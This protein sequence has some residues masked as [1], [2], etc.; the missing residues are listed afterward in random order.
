MVCDV[1]I[2]AFS[3][4]IL[5]ATMDSQPS[6]HRSNQNMALRSAYVVHL[7]NFIRSISIFSLYVFP[8]IQRTL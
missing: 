1:A 4:P 8:Q 5:P 3:H 6:N 7:L 2:A